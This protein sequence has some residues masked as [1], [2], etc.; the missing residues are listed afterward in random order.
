MAKRLK[1]T[2]LRNYTIKKKVAPNNR[3]RKLRF[4][5]CQ[6]YK[7]WRV[8]DW[9]KVNFSDECNVDAE[10]SGDLQKVRRKP[11]E[12][13]AAIAIKQVFYCHFGF[14][15][16]SHRYNNFKYFRDTSFQLQ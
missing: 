12:K 8:E 14:A 13:N 1:E 16:S 9:H 4:E 10:T 2:G 11:S 15:C 6:K 5:F 3:H 7:D